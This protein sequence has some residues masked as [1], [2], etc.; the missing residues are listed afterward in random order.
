MGNG[1]C[2]KIKEKICPNKSSHTLLKDNPIFTVL[3]ISDSYTFQAQGDYHKM[4]NYDLLFS[5]LQKPLVIIYIEEILR[6]SKNFKSYHFKKV[7]GIYLQIKPDIDALFK[8]YGIKCK[9]PKKSFYLKVITY[10]IDCMPSTE[11]DL[12]MFMPILFIE[13]CLYPKSFIKKSKI[14]QIILVND[15]Q[16]TTPYFSQYRAGCPEYNETESLMLSTQERNFVYIRIVFH[17]ELFHYV[18]WIDDFSY[19]DSAW[20]KINTPGFKYGKGG[21]YEREWVQLEPNIQGFINHYSTTALEEDRAE[22]YQYLMGCPDEALNNKDMIVQKKVKRIKE[23]IMKFDSKG[24][25]NKKKNYFG[26]LMDFRNKIV[27]KEAVFQGNI[28]K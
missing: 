14:K 20:E 2:Q 6:Q 26:N 13:L 11:D 25:G 12:D 15:I 8:R 7:K 4:E 24:I 1:V 19:S 23:F 21:E 16:F 5:F 27:Y 22:I 3:Q 18:D 28:P 10:K 9:I 17:H